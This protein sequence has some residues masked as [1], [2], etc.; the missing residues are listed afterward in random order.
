MKFLLDTGSSVSIIS[1]N[2]IPF[3]K[4]DPFINDIKLKEVTGH[5]IDVAGTVTLE[6]EANGI[7]FEYDMLVV[8]N[9]RAGQNINGIIGI[10]FVKYFNVLIDTENRPMT[11]IVT[12]LQLTDASPEVEALSYQT[13]CDFGDALAAG[14]VPGLGAY[15]E[16][17]LVAQI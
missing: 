4:I 14:G 15:E 2:A 12:Q 3:L 7:L 5:T 9:F 16:G 11:L 13:V 10:D 17:P 1:K 6:F 8:E